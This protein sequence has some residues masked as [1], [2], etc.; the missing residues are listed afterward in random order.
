MKTNY[1]AQQPQTA[2]VTKRNTQNCGFV[3]TQ[4]A[5]MPNGGLTSH[6]TVNTPS[7]NANHTHSSSQGY[8]P[9]LK[10]TFVDQNGDFQATINT[11][12]NSTS[13]I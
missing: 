3:P 4:V 1:Q 11:I 6:C 9:S 13:V 8:M 12:E 2:E 7:R 5:T 10:N